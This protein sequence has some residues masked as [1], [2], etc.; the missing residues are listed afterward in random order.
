MLPHWLSTTI[1]VLADPEEYIEGQ[2]R[3]P[4]LVGCL[5]YLMVCTKPDLAHTLSV[6]GSFVAEGRHGPEH[7]QA[8]LRALGYVKATK[9]LRLRLGGSMEQL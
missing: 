1:S 6:L 3:F 2:E 4:E 7:L 8:A 5:M 9:H